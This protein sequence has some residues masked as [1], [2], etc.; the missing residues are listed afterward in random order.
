MGCVGPA[1]DVVIT[2]EPEIDIDAV[3]DHTICSNSPTNILLNSNAVPSA[4]DV[5]FNVSV[6]VTAGAATGYNLVPFTVLNGN[7]IADNLVNFGV[8]NAIVE[9]TITPVA[10][11]AANTGGCFGTPPLVVEVTVE[12]LPQVTSGQFEQ[13]CSEVQL[14]Y[15]ITTTP[16]LPGT[17]FTW[18]APVV[19]GGIT[20]GNARVVASS[21]NLDDAFINNTGVRQTAIYT[22][23]PFGPSVNTCVGNPVDITIFVDPLPT[24]VLSVDN[25]VIC[26]NGGSA[27]LSFAMT[28]TP[29]FEI[30]YDEG[31]G[32]ITVSNISNLHFIPVFGL[33]ATTTYTLQTVTDFNG[34]LTT[35]NQ[36]VVVTVEQPVS[37]FTMDTNSGCTPLEVVFTNNDVQAGTVYEW[38]FG[39]GSPI[40][41][42][43]AGTVTHTYI[44][45][46]NFSAVSF[47]PTLT[48]TI[49][50][51][52]VVCTDVSFDNVTIEPSVLLNVTPSVT[53]GCSPLTVNFNNISQGV[54]SSKW[55][56]REQGTAGEND[57]QTSFPASYTLSNTGTASQIIEVVYQGTRNGC[58]DEIVTEITV[59]PE[60]VADFT[61]APGTTVSINSPTIT[62]T[63]TTL[64]QNSWI[65]LWEWGDGQTT[66]NIDPGS[67]TYAAFGVYELKLTVRDPSGICESIKIVPITVEPTVPVVDF[68]VDITEGC[69]PL[70]VQFTNLS[71]SVDPNTYQWTFVDETG[72]II[73]VSTAENPEFTFFLPGIINVTLEGS[74]P[75]G[76]S[77]IETKLGYIEI[78]ELPTA[79]FSVR[80]DV[81]FLPDQ[82]MFTS[83]L[84]RLADEFWW[85]FDGDG[86]G[87]SEE[88]E[89]SFQYT[90]PGVYDVALIAV[91]SLT[92][93]SD[94]TILEQAVTV[95]ESGSSDIPNGF[96]PGSGIGGDGSIGG[97]GAGGS[98]TVFLPRIKGVRDDGFMMQVFDR[99]GHLLFE[100]NVKTEGW[101]GRLFSTG[102]LMPAGVYVYKLEL[103]Y[104]SGEQT[105]IVGDIN[106]IR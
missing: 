19:T 38:N 40:V 27:L 86:L 12:P 93:C 35:I 88:F 7:T 67:H 15:T 66:T 11:S 72:A 42:T 9:Y 92:G 77:D 50:N 20:G 97:G 81:V 31:A 1:V 13:V 98:N 79:S 89:P 22:V 71:T 83:N 70:T 21:A 36:A 28:G 25:P 37:A 73:G 75:L 41:N 65:T 54:L 102:K 23:T 10:A 33:A 94:T 84:S 100:S 47:V 3:A 55:F 62:V 44:N 8:A 78:Y 90:D 91:N 51:G 16:D 58:S 96:F 82:L 76:V 17:T 69:M 74:N 5:T 52:A 63:N 85:D 99:W 46:S 43:N 6:M 39:D 26:F 56:W 14:G 45:N 30:V 4:G 60:V 61:V 105:T 104:I 80:P 101:N 87:D 57:I 34:C 106:L 29:P 24:G 95:V 32:P 68:T 48:A 103:V 53:E 49:T 59:Y 64:N 18:H 2:V